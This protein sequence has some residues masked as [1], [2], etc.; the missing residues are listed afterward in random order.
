[1]TKLRLLVLCFPY[2]SDFSIVFLYCIVVQ[3][4]KEGVKTR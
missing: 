2:F 4:K 3:K 1:M